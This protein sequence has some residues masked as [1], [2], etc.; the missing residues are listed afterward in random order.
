MPSSEV[1]MK[2]ASK[3]RK[4][5]ADDSETTSNKKQAKESDVYTA[6][7]VPG[8]P[9]THDPVIPAAVSGLVIATSAES[10][11]EILSSTFGGVPTSLESAKP[12]RL[13][14]PGVLNVSAGPFM[15]SSES[16]DARD[17]GGESM[18]LF[19]ARHFPSS[20]LFPST[21]LIVAPSEKAAKMQVEAYC[22]EHM[23]GTDMRPKK[24]QLSY[25]K[26]GLIEAVDMGKDAFYPL[27]DG[28]LYE[29]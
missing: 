2:S 14:K 26:T 22:K 18:K 9:S 8:L 1:E 15:A 10:A 13:D 23:V 24:I 11:S 28:Q 25:G 16:K 21:A 20:D 3:S 19:V 12:V 7:Y 4:R 27:V 29:Y 6:L 5:A 17:K